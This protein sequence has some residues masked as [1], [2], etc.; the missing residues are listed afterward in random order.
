[1][2]KI[3]TAAAMVIISMGAAHAL[4]GYNS[5]KLTCAQAQSAINAKGEAIRSYPSGN[6]SGATLSARYV[7]DSS[8][9]SGSEFAQR[10]YIPT[11]DSKDCPVF[12]CAPTQG[13]HSFHDY[14]RMRAIME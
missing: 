14:Q 13:D 10:S 12:T 5:T 3:M 4:S 9:C 1:M 8:A 2:K 11:S 7:K 6:A